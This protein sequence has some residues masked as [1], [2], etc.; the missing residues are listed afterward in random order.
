MAIPRRFFRPTWA[1]VHLQALRENIRRFRRR[2]RQMQRQYAAGEL[3]WPQVKVRLQAWNA[4][5]ATAAS[6]RLRERIF[7]SLPFVRETTA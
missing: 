3:D 1:E 5:A 4:H 6:Y 7:A 2:A